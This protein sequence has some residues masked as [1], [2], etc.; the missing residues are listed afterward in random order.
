MSPYEGA[1]ACGAVT[2]TIEGEI[3]QA[4]VCHCTTCQACSGGVALL[5][6]V[7]TPQVTLMGTEN[8]TTWKSSDWAERGFCSTCGSSLYSLLTAGPMQGYYYFGAGTL[9]DW[10]DIKLGGEYF[11]DRKPAGYEF[12]SS[13][14]KLTAEETFAMYAAMGADEAKHDE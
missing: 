8:I 9:K 3:K 12:A 13:C 6:A 4:D 5:V 14:K 2:Y 7:T 11:I 1:C 10:K